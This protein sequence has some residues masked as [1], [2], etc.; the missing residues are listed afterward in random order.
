[1]FDWSRDESEANS[2][3]IEAVQHCGPVDVRLALY[4]KDKLCI[5]GRAELA[6]LRRAAMQLCVALA[7]IET[8]NE[9][10]RLKGVIMVVRTPKNGCNWVDVIYSRAV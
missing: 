6:K 10:A 7:Q 9:Q 5:E 2:N 3:L 4:L 1:M 8:L